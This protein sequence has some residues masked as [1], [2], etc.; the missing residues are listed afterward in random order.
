MLLFSEMAVLTDLHKSN[1]SIMR[2]L[3]MGGGSKNV[4][5]HDQSAETTYFILNCAENAVCRC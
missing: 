2:G 5:P 1:I 3:I 4:Y